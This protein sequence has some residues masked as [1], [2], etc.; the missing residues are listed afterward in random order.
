M[1]SDVVNRQEIEESV[2]AIGFDPSALALEWV[3]LEDT[4]EQPT[5]LASAI[6]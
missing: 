1:S 5:L 4:V 2:R 6:H 3:A